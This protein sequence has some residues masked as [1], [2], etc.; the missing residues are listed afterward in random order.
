MVPVP[1]VLSLPKCHP[2]QQPAKP[3][4]GILL[5]QVLTH[6]VVLLPGALWDRDGLSPAGCSTHHLQMLARWTYLKQNDEHL[7]EVAR[8]VSNDVSLQVSLISW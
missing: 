2:S 7:L 6:H 3:H 5:H 8:C 4:L 1:P